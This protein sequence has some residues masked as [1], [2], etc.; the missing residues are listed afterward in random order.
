MRRYTS[1]LHVGWLIYLGSV[2]NVDI[3]HA[4]DYNICTLSFIRTSKETLEALA[5]LT[6]SCTISPKMGRRGQS[7]HIMSKLE[8]ESLEVTFLHRSQSSLSKFIWPQT[9]GKE[10]KSWVDEGI[11]FLFILYIYETKD[12]LP[13]PSII[14]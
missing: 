8:E 4:L 9:V 6:N 10:D 12:R 2:W 5:Q 7:V 14:R 1:A 11:K 13:A 3:S